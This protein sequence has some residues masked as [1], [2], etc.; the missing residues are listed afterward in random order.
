MKPVTRVLLVSFVASLFIGLAFVSDQPVWASAA[1]QVPDPGA[2]QALFEVNPAAK[3][4]KV[5][6]TL[7]IVYTSPRD[8]ETDECANEG[9]PTVDMYIAIRAKR[10]DTADLQVA[11]L[12]ERGVCYFLFGPGTKQ[13]DA[14]KRAITEQLLP[15]LFPA[16][17]TSFQVKNV[18]NF[19]QDEANDIET[20]PFFLMTDFTLAV[21]TPKSKGGH[22]DKD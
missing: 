11:G 4:R 15:K 12:L 1:T 16:G 14:V 22:D 2:F 8:G 18:E 13:N 10:R 9:S 5:V 3:G 21:V 17:F 20:E 19:V 6:G 7:S